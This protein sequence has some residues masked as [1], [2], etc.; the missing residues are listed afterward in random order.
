MRDNQQVLWKS[1][2]KVFKIFSFS[3]FLVLVGLKELSLKCGV[4]ICAQDDIPSKLLTKHFFLND[5]KGHFVE[6]N[7]RKSKWLLIATYHPPSQ[8]DQH[9]VDLTED[10]NAEISDHHLETF[11]Y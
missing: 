3:Q 10:C 7:F 1:Q 8:S 6:L 2:P 4:T 9:Y 11:L 5:I